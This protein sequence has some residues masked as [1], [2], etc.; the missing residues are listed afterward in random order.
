MKLIDESYLSGDFT[1]ALCP[2]IANS[3][4][5]NYIRTLVHYAQEH[6]YRCAVLNHLG[7]LKDI[8]LTSNHIFSY[9]G[10]DELEAMMNKLFEIYPL[11][12]FINVGFSM[13][14]NVTTRYLAKVDHEK[15]SKILI[16]L[17]VCQGYCAM[18]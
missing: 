6:G 13:G 12:K 4:E 3:S 18:S 15:R 2:G 14:A 5:S 7:A 17:S 16:G 1:L 10:T 11:T 8:Q 9:G